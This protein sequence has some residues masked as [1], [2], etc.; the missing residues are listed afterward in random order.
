MQCQ[1]ISVSHKQE[2]RSSTEQVWEKHGEAGLRVF[3]ERLIDV[4]TPNLETM[5]ADQRG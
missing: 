1:Q 3:L 2:L 5:A 4:R